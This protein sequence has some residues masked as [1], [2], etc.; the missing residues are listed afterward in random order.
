MMERTKLLPDLHTR[1]NV[2]LQTNVAKEKSQTKILS[3]QSFM[4]VSLLQKHK[5]LHNSSLAISLKYRIKM[6]LEKQQ[7][8]LS[9]SLVLLLQRTPV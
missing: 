5:I 8:K 1:T 4:L 3:P 7:Y 2:C 6:R 9:G